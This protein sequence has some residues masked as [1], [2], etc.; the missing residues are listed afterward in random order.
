M[1]QLL[2]PRA[3]AV[4]QERQELVPA[5]VGDRPGRL[6]DVAEDREAGYGPSRDHPQLHRRQ[7]LRL[8][9]DHVA[10]LVRRPEQQRSGLVEER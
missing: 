9:D 1:A 7:V 8:V 6:G 5:V 4:G 3:L 10:V 2:D